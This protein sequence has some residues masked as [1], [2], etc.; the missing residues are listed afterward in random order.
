V[1]TRFQ[2]PPF[3]CILQRYYMY[4]SFATNLP[5]VLIAAVALERISFTHPF[6]PHVGAL[7]WLT[8]EQIGEAVQ[9]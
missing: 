6:D 9:S 2:S 5:L 4:L 3:K 1:K 7:G 8:R